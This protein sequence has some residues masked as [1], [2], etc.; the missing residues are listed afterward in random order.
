MILGKRV[1]V[2]MPAYHAGRTVEK[3]ASAM[4]RDVID[5]VIFVDDASGDDGYEK[6]VKAGL[7]AFRNE[8]NLNYGGNVKRCLQLALDHG[9]D[10]AVLLHPDCQYTPSLVPAMAA[11]LCGTPYDLCLAS[12]TSGAGTVS[13]GMPF[14]RYLPN[15]VITT[16]MSWCLGVRHTEYHTGYRAYSR[17]LLE[18]VPFHSYRNDFI[19]D[20]QTLIGAMERGF[21]TCEVTCPTVYQDD[22]SSIPF[23]KSVRYGLQCLKISLPFLRKRMLGQVQPPRRWPEGDFA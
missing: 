13:A 10:I 8:R 5:E 16:Y 3:M 6:A 7:T 17:R 9:A 19:F 23:G 14:W 21:R 11:M 12:R 4:P 2:T 22:S 18:A 1:I 15:R 20:N